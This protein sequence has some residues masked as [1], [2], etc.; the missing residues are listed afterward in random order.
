MKIISNREY[1]Q[2]VINTNNLANVKKVCIDSIITDSEPLWDAFLR[3]VAA[4]CD[5]DREETKKWMNEALRI[6][7][8]EPLNP[9]SGS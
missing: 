5:G 7:K 6:K 4:L 2:L 1:N 3:G 8:L 9:S